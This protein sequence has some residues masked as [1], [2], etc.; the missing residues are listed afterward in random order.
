MKYFQQHRKP[1]PMIVLAGLVLIA[2]LGLSGSLMAQ[3]IA[4]TEEAEAT[5]EAIDP[6]DCEGSGLTAAKAGIDALLAD[7]DTQAA[8]DPSAALEAL[9]LVSDA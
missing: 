6:A 2:M 3:T 5:E 9:F 1:Y 8:D 4:P 7:F